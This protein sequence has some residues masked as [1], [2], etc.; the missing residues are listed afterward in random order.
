M[1]M[2]PANYMEGTLN[3]AGEEL[4]VA[5]SC[6]K[7]PYA[8][9]CLNSSWPNLPL[10][11]Q[12]WVVHALKKKYFKGRIPLNAFYKQAWPALFKGLHPPPPPNDI[13][14]MRCHHIGVVPTSCRNSPQIPLPLKRYNLAALDNDVNYYSA[15]KEWYQ[16]NCIASVSLYF[17]QLLPCTIATC[18]QIIAFHISLWHPKTEA[19]FLYWFSKAMFSSPKAAVSLQFISYNIKVW[20]LFMILGLI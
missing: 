7:K 5:V 4:L 11:I 13:I 8:G 12:V 19:P 15:L 2:W 18:L 14:S 3:L 16:T 6:K 17:E 10:E 1:D 9:V 20:L